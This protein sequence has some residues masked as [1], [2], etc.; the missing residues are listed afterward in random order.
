MTADQ[1]RLIRE[2]ASAH[3][4]R[5]GGILSS[6]DISEDVPI[7]EIA[8]AIFRARESDVKFDRAIAGL[9][10]RLHGEIYESVWQLVAAFQSAAFAFGCGVGL[11]LGAM[12]APAPGGDV[13]AAGELRSSHKPSC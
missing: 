1:Y 8:N 5:G 6:E 9:D 3:V 7:T 4:L 2:L 12:A 10:R 13:P 11:Q